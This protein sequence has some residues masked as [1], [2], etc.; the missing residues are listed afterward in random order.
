M[1]PASLLTG[2]ILPTLLRL[3]LPNVLALTMSVAVGI[4]ETR[5]V[6]QL[7]AAPLAAMAVVFPLVMLVQMMSAGAMGGG[8]SSAVSRALGAGDEARARALAWHAVAIGT[9]AGVL[10]GVLLVGGGR[11]LYRL[12]GARGEVLE[13]AAGYGTVLFSGSVLIWLLNTLASVL[14]GTGDMRVPSLVLL[15]T[16]GLQILL[17]GALG[18]GL[19]PV[20][21]LGM[22]GIALGQVLASALGTAVLAGWL[23]SGRARLRLGWRGVALRG[24]LLADI[25]KVGALACLSPVQTVLTAVIV[26]GLIAQLGLPALAGYAIG[27]RLEFLLVPIAFGIGVAAVPMVGMAI[28]AGDVARARRVA[29]TAGALSAVNV[30]LIGAVVAVAPELWATWFTDDP[31]V[32]AYASQYLRWAGPAFAAFGFGLTLYFASQGSGRVLGA[33]LAA[34]VRLALVAAAGAWLAARGAPAWQFFALVAVAMG[35]Y[36]AGVAASVHF[37]RWGPRATEPRERPHDAP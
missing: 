13:L 10:T 20:P 16:G 28:G 19:G 6:G 37:T 11:T 22:P 2:P 25:L 15:G 5:Y 33:V 23:V 29:W 4:A 31:Q 14:R 12:L 9:V 32:L 27:Q 26:T 17:G 34:G 24:G 1:P 3:A 7:G 18:L 36:G 8:V 21:R 35:V 30:G